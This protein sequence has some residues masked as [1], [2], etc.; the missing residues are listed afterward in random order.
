[1]SF[2]FLTPPEILFG[3]G[4]SRKAL[5]AARRFGSRVFLITGARSFDALPIAPMF[6][7]LRRWSVS[8][9]RTSRPS[10]R[11]SAAAATRT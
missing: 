6:S 10:T 5:D 8:G 7:G 11:A 3:P 1:V 2:S 9:S 4:E